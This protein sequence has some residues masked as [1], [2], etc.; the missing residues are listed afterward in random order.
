MNIDK[1][2]ESAGPQ[3]SPKIGAI[4]ATPRPSVAESS[5]AAN[6]DQVDMSMIGRLLARSIRALADSEEVRPSVLEQH[7][8]L[9]SQNTR[10]DNGTIDRIFR[11]MRGN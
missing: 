4:G 8:D 7:R 3:T 2:S 10:F 5:A 6:S 11:R 1:L 9:P